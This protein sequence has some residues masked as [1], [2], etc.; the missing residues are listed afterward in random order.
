M[1]RAALARIRARLRIPRAEPAGALLL[2]AMKQKKANPMGWPFLY[3]GEGKS[4][5][6][7][8]P[9]WILGPGHLQKKDTVNDTV[10]NSHYTLRMCCQP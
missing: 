1:P 9:A 10:K 8:K 2:S 3:S 4:N 7:L 5:Q 6:G